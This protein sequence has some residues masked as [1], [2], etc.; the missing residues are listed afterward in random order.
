MSDLAADRDPALVSRPRLGEAALRIEGVALVDRGA[1]FAGVVSDAATDG[2]HALVVL[3]RLRVAALAL[4]DEAQA[5]FGGGLGLLV[6][7]SPRAL[8]RAAVARLGFGE[9]RGLPV[10]RAKR[11]RRPTAEVLVRRRLGDER[12]LPRRLLLTTAAAEKTEHP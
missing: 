6:P 12:S 3:R 5:V 1:G 4:G 11:P 7:P 10:H 9:S 2:E 8:L